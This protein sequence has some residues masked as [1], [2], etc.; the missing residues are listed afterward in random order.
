MKIALGDKS[1]IN[2]Y[3]FV[4]PMDE[5]RADVTLDLSGRSYC[6]FDGKFQREK[7]GDLATELIS[8]FFISLANSL[9]ATIHI[10]VTGENTHH[11]IESVFKC[12]GRALRQAITK[13]GYDIPSTK[14]VL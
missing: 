14:G 3:G 2:R 10:K 6:V 5:S 12:V 1:G 11:M 4:L 7:V 8:H 9:G 13:Q